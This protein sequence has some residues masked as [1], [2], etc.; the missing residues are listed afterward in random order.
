[1]RV[2][3]GVAERGVDPRLELLREDVLEPV[4]LRVHLV[5]RH[6]E[7]VGEVELEQPVMPQHL[8]RAQ[9]AAL[10]EH[11]TAVR[12]PLD[13]AELGEPLHH[14]RRRRGA[15]VHPLRKRGRRRP[16]SLGPEGVDRLEVV[17]DRARELRA[18]LF[19]GLG[20]QRTLQ[21]DLRHD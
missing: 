3:G 17:L 9:T 5:E 8:E 18:S 19:H 11:D 1:M 16:L 12:R 7:R 10:G 6:P 2:V 13:E 15:D 21:F 20:D 4:G 14:R